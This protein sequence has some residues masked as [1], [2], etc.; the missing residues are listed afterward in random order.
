MNAAKTSISI[1]ISCPS[2]ITIGFDMEPFILQILKLK[3]LDKGSYEFTFVDK[4]TI[5]SINKKYLNLFIKL[6]NNVKN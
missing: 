6:M 3:N 5:V 2:S 1:Q 4:D